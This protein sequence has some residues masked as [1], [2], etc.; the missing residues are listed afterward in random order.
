MEARVGRRGVATAAATAAAAEERDA[1]E[2]REAAEKEV[3]VKVEVVEARRSTR[4][5]GGRTECSDYHENPVESVAP[6]GRKTG[7]ADKN[8][9]RCVTYRFECD[10][11]RSLPILLLL[12][13]STLFLAVR[14]SRV[15]SYRALTPFPPS[16]ARLDLH[17][18]L[19]LS[20]SLFVSSSF[21]SLLSR[22]QYTNPIADDLIRAILETPVKYPP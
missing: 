17:Q 6:R 14:L 1:G 20:L 9:S 16:L 15:P 12:S 22:A 10:G 11:R 18:V 13:L 5:R 19:S 7:P 4:K 3:E 8:H 21:L 2:G